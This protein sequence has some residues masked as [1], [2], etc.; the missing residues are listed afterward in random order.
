LLILAGAAAP[1]RSETLNLLTWESYINPVLIERWKALSHTDI[2]QVYY[3]NGDDRDLILSKSSSQIDIVVIEN[4][5]IGH[6]GEHGLLTDLRQTPMPSM[7][8]DSPKSREACGSYGA[9]YLWGND[10]ILYRSD[11]VA[12]PPTSWHDLLQPAAALH[13]HVAMLEDNDDLLAVPLLVLNKRTDTDNVAD[14]RDGFNLL[15]VQAP[16]VL[17]FDY[18]IT[19]EQEPAFKGKIYMALGYTGD[20]VVLNRNAP[21]SARWRFVTPKEGTVI[22]VDCLAVIDHSARRDLA[23]KFIAFLN[24]PQNAADNASYLNLPTPNDRALSLMGSAA[25][26]N[27]EIYPSAD[28]IARSQLRGKIPE[29]TLQLRR[30]M[31]SALA[32]LH[33]AQ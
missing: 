20:Q 5:R 4:A 6:L 2:N 12:T 28:V 1:A 25:R 18:V 23:L 7:A 24:E 16:S 27:P 17:T 15:K 33:D 11:K 32:S 29:A 13:Q 10:G 14:L 30:R 26:N 19:A 31:V 9:P 8:S 3:D 22:W 21:A